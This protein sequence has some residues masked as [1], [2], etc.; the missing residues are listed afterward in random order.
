M[1]PPVAATPPGAAGGGPGAGGD[2]RPCGGWIDL[3]GCLRW[4]TRPL[5][6][7]LRGRLRS[8]SRP[9]DPG[10][11][12]SAAAALPRAPENLPVG[13]DVV[14]AGFPWAARTPSARAASGGTVI[15]NGADIYGEQGITREVYSIRG[16]VRSGNSGGPLLTPDGRVAGTVFAMSA[17]DPQTGYVLTDA[18]T[19]PLLDAAG[20]LAVGAGA[21]RWLSGGVSDQRAFG[22]AAR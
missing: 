21:H 12:G 3:G 9:G 16:Q 14:A 13:A 20:A 18:A 10:S 6:R 15:E 17:L 22:S 8:R 1:P 7:H 2:Q 5:A 4:W 11:A 19:A